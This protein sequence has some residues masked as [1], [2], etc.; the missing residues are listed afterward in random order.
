VNAKRYLEL[1][2]AIVTATRCLSWA[3]ALS[4]GIA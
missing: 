2:A 4:V 1:S 3:T